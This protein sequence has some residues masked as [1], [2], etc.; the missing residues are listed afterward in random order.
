MNT[1]SSHIALPIKNDMAK[2]ILLAFFGSIVIAIAA[3]ITVPMY[4]VP[5]T[6]QTMA[7]F[8]VAMILGGRYGALAI[9]FYLAEGAMGL[10]VF[11]GGKASIVTLMG[12][13]GG[14]LFGYVFGAYIVGTLAQKGWDRTMGKAILAMV[15]GSVALY[16]PGLVQLGTVVGWDKPILAWGLT[17][18]II[19]DTVKIIVASGVFSVIWN[20]AVK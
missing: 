20:K 11:A 4:P 8:S 12:P 15:L 2:H 13:S 1:L 18:F 7:V 5:M 10:P 3:Q 9:I 6:L 14:Y 19:G 17:P 16:V